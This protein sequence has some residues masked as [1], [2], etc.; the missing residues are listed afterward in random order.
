[1]SEPIVEVKEARVGGECTCYYAEADATVPT[2]GTSQQL[3]HITDLSRSSTRE[4]VDTSV[5]ADYPDG[6]EKPGKRTNEVT[7]TLMNWKNSEG[8]YMPDVQFIRNA[9][10][11]GKLIKLAVLDGPGG[12]GYI[13]TG[14]CTDDEES[15]GLNDPHTWSITFK[16]AQARIKV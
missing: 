10:D 8:V 11:E 3:K 7:F 4:S 14:Y 12:N 9:V 13:F 15:Q 16:S 5:R 6:S 2:S 1:M